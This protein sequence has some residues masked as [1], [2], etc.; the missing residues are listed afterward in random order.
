MTDDQHAAADLSA[1][2][3]LRARLAAADPAASLSAADPAG[4]ARLLEDIMSQTPETRCDHLRHRSRLTWAIAAAVAVVIVG[5]IAFALGN[6]GDDGPAVAATDVSPSAPVTTPTEEESVTE[7]SLAANG[8]SGRCLTPEA[9]PQVVSSQSLVVD[10]TVESI[11]AG[12]VTLAPT[13]FYTGEETD[14]VTVSE[15]SG[16]L[17]LL[18]AGVEFEE[19]ER[20]LV[21]A[22]DGQVTLCGFSGPY[23]ERLAA[24]YDDAFSD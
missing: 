1:D 20:Y 6:D 15:P 16:D 11:S 5:G 13:R 12:V 22:T 14:I 8:T 2:D 23:S 9:A 18:L 10:A 19:G 3:A 21:S 7:L 17:Q 4:V 24:V